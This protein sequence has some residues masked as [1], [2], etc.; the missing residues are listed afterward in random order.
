MAR[1]RSI[2]PEFWTD[3]FLARR[4]SRDARMLYTGLWNLA[5][6]HA[7][8][9]GDAHYIKG[10]LFPYDDDLTPGAIDALLDALDDAGRVIR[11]IDGGDPY[12]FLPYL[13]KHQRLEP[14]KVPSKLPAPPE[15]L[16]QPPA[17]QPETAK[18]QV[19]DSTQIGAD[20]SESRADESAP[21]A[22][23][24]A[25]LYVAGSR[26]HVAGSME[27][28]PPRA[29]TSQ[30]PLLLLVES[31]PLAPLADEPAE[32]SKRNSAS[33]GKRASKPKDEPHPRFA[34]FWDAYNHKVGLPSA[35]KAFNAAA[36]AGADPDVLIAA[37]GRYARHIKRTRTARH[38]IK[39]PSGWLN[40]ERWQDDLGPDED[41]APSAEVQRANGGNRRD[42]DLGS[43]EHMARFLAR[44]AERRQAAGA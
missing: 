7:R 39:H 36:A 43:D 34:E 12:L 32:A 4:L 13:D 15:A 24:N 14:E 20:S 26:E 41:P 28:V 11:Y 8:L 23:E 29:D 9:N 1:I 37:A 21:R 35:I 16:P 25:L 27:H 44:Q 38:H 3:R 6:E 30:P 5:D 17:P 22:E 31:E 18:V 10:Q 19:K 40:D 42:G 2:K 33:K